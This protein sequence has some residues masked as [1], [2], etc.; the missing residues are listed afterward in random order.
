LFDLVLPSRNESFVGKAVWREEERM[1]VRFLGPG[2]L[3]ERPATPE[4]E[5]GVSRPY[6]IPLELARKLRS[7][8]TERAVLRRR[9]VELSESG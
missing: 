5:P 2:H 6:A 7:C 4:R 3:I 9:V 8:E 1:G